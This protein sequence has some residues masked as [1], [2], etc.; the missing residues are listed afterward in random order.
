MEYNNCPRLF[1]SKDTVTELELT[2]TNLVEAK[3]TLSAIRNSRTLKALVLLSSGHDG[4]VEEVCKNALQGSRSL[5]HVTLDLANCTDDGISNVVVILRTVAK[6][7]SMSLRLNN[8]THIGAESIAGVLESDTLQHFSVHGTQMD[9]ND[10]LIQDTGAVHIA[11]ATLKCLALKHIGIARNGITDKGVGDLMPILEMHPAIATLDLS[12]NQ[13]SKE[14]V[15]TIAQSLQRMPRLKN[16]ILDSN[17][18]TA[19][20]QL[21]HIDHTHSLKFLSL[22]S[23]NLTKDS[24]AP[25]TTY[26][27]GGLKALNLSGNRDLGNE[28]VHLLG[29]ALRGNHTLQSLDLSSCSIDDEGCANFSESLLSSSH[30]SLTHLYLHC[31]HIGDSGLVSLATALQ[32][33]R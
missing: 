18:L 4:E 17:K 5:E 22:R 30:S 9:L 33:N 13:I 11:K 8:V 7:V 32:T 10:L 16:L 27:N 14:G 24:I 12:G 20:D 6:L 3:P 2:V 15:A 1:D 25:L 31:N 19:P 26:I 21:S 28:G 29:M 23:C